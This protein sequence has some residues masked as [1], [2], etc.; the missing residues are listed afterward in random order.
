MSILKDKLRQRIHDKRQEVKAVM[1]DHGEETISEVSVTQHLFPDHIKSVGEEMG[2]PSV[3]RGGW[4]DA[5]DYRRRFPDGRIGSHPW[6][7]TPAAGKELYELAA[8]EVAGD[9]TKFLE[10]A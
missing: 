10:E 8:E 6:L 3:H 5:E 7:A 2:P 1:R 4:A 9:F